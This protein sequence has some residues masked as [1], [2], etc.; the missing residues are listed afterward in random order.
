M[1]GNL[2]DDL[3]TSRS[4]KVTRTRRLY[5]VKAHCNPMLDVARET[6][7]ENTHDIMQCKSS[8]RLG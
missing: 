6:Y 7:K 4:N 5:A 3:N 2:N 8:R 1:P